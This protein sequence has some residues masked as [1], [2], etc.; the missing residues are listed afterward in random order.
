M[1][2]DMWKIVK[3]AFELWLRDLIELPELNEILEKAG[4][5]K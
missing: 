4:M 3:V 2:A 5:V 1:T